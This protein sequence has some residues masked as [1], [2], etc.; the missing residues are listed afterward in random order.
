MMVLAM[1]AV[2]LVFG[3]VWGVYVDAEQG[4][5]AGSYVL[6]A[7]AVFLAYLAFLCGCESG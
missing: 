2:S 5:A 7:C 3:I 1:L 4:I 6:A